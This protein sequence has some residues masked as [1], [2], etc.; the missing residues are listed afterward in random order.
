M[1]DKAGW[2]IGAGVGTRYFSYNFAEEGPISDWF[3]FGDASTGFFF[4]GFTLSYTFSS[5]MVSKL[6]IGYSYRFK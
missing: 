4:R 5:D 1:S 3:F 6:A 2:Y